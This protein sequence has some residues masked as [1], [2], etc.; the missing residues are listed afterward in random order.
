[1]EP[2]HPKNT[3]TNSSKSKIK[4]KKRR[5][6]VLS[7]QEYLDRMA[8]IVRRDYFPGLH[9]FYEEQNG[10]IDIPSGSLNTFLSKH[11]SEDN[12]SFGEINKANQTRHR[13]FM[14]DV[15]GSKHDRLLPNS[16]NSKLLLEQ[17][18]K[19]KEPANV[20]LLTFIK[21]EH[22]IPPVTV[23]KQNT[24]FSPWNVSTTGHT[25]RSQDSK[26]GFS[27]PDDPKGNNQVPLTPRLT[28]KPEDQMFTLGRVEGVRRLTRNGS[29][30]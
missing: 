11:T 2:K 17:E 4:S 16:T 20:P 3:N 22:V 23:K 8:A 21:T 29:G 1:M 7:E 6:R 10:A 13:K 18:E 25:N 28:P 15:Y 5:K 14:A 24:R 9:K 26:N 12:H 19:R 30:S 27:I